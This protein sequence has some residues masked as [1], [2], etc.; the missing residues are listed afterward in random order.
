VLLYHA[1]AAGMI[2]YG[3][4]AFRVTIVA[5]RRMQLPPGTVV[6]ATHRRETDVPLVAPALYLRAQMWRRGAPRLDFAARDDM[7]LPGFF[8]GF[9][10]E[11]PVRAR[12]ALFPV[13][14]GRWLPRVCVHP[15]RSASTVRLGEALRARRGEAL[16]D[17]LE[18]DEAAAFRARAAA[19]GLPTPARA[20]DALRGEYADLLWRAVTPSHPAGAGLDEFWSRRALD[21]A[22]DFRALVDVVEGGGVLLVFPEGRPSPDGAIGP[23]QRGVDALVRRARPAA[24]VPAALAYDPLTRGR[25][26]VTVAIGP[27]ESPASDVLRLLRRT[28]PLTAGQLAAAAP[29]DE[30]LA[31]ARST[32]R[33]VEPDL[34]DAATRER[35]LREAAAVAPGRPDAVAI[36]AREY[37]SARET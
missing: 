33:P 36:L 23:L 31:E 8:A 22:A 26:R 16:A 19:C 13:G 30:A 29:V 3:R 21:A 17:V 10:E 12:R 6:V 34:L 5:P 25:T 32:G 9:P 14:V 18:P 27:P 35:R 24:L 2:A 37:E 28:M 15:I 11:L 20:G 1:V 4:A 7:F